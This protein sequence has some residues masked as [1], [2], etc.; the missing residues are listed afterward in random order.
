MLSARAHP[1]A[2][3]PDMTD[4]LG[5]GLEKRRNGNLSVLAGE[6]TFRCVSAANEAGIDTYWRT[7]L[8]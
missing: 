5:Y 1:F 7:I 3:L 4:N 8:Q 6:V 2:P